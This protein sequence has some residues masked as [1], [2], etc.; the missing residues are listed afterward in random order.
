M[1]PLPRKGPENDA[2]AC[3][4][5]FDAVLAALLAGGA[6]ASAITVD[7]TRGAKAMSAAAVLAAVGREVKCLR[8]IEGER[9]ERGK[10]LPGTERLRDVGPALA[11][12][13]RDPERAAQFLDRLQFSAVEP[14]LGKDAEGSAGAHAAEREWAV[15]LAQFWRAS[16]RFDYPAA[17]ALLGARPQPA[18]PPGWARFRPRDGNAVLASRLSSLVALIAAPATAP[19]DGSVT[20]PTS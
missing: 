13:R 2:A 4:A 15:W 19:A 3:F 11:T 8:Y 20:R 16:D 10:V 7:F 9:D 17:A 14:L 1:H 18:A 6:P 5:H 12:V